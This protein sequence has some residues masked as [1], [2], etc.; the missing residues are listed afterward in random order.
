MGEFVFPSNTLK[1]DKIKRIR[2]TATEHINFTCVAENQ[3]GND[4]R[5]VSIEIIGKI[6]KYRIKYIFDRPKPI[7]KSIQ[8]VIYQAVIGLSTDNFVNYFFLNYEY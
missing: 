7:K 1:Y 8:Y 6:R 5:T 4:S 2:K 3:F